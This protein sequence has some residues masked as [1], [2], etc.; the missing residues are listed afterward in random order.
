ML[1]RNHQE[2]H[3]ASKSCLIKLIETFELCDVW[4]H[5]YKSQRQYTWVHSRDNSVPGQT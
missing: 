2:P 3:A 4:R 5:F 1:D